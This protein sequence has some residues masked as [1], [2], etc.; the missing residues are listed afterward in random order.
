MTPDEWLL[1]RFDRQDALQR[2]HGRLTLATQRAVVAWGP[3]SPQA[4]CA[5]RARWDVEALYEELGGLA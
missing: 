1:D 5:W 4:V 2:L 3:R